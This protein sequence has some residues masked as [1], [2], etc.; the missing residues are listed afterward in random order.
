MPDNVAQSTSN[1]I[2]GS[3]Y[4]TRQRWR[5]SESAEKWSRTEADRG[6]WDMV[7]SE[8][9]KPPMNHIFSATAVPVNLERLPW[10]HPQTPLHGRAWEVKATRMND[11]RNGLTYAQAGVDI[12]A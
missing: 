3:G 8:S 12:D 9:S 5:G 4:S 2:S 1:R 10:G 7:S 11:K 6:R